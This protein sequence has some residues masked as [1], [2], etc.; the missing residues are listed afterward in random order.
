MVKGWRLRALIVLMSV[1]FARTMIEVENRNLQV[2]LLLLS[3]LLLVA[4]RRGDR[5]WGGLALG[6][7]LAIKLVQAPVLL[8][9]LWGRRWLLVVLALGTWAV[10][11]SVAVPGLLHEDLFQVLPTVGRGSRG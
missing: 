5:W 10:L 6:L 2:L 8:L 1:S 7:G 4:W 3:G 9:G 11:W